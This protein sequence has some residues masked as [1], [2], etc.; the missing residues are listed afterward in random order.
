MWIVKYQKEI[1]N[2]M[3]DPAVTQ[4]LKPAVID[5]ISSNALFDQCRSMIYFYKPLVE[6][7]GVCSGVFFLCFSEIWGVFV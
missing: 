6:G 7:L 1:V 4:Y 5:S 3:H 2:I